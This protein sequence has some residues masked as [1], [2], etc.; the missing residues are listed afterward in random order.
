MVLTYEPVQKALLI[1]TPVEAGVE[2]NLNMPG[3]TL[4]R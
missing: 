3:F 2:K 4:S 1:G